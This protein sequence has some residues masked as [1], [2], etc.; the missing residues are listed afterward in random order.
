MKSQRRTLIT[1]FTL[2]I[3]VLLSTQLVFADREP[4]GP[5]D[6]NT[7]TGGF[8]VDD[9]T[10]VLTPTDLGDSL[11]GPGITISTVTYT[12][13]D[14]A[15]GGFSGGAGIIGFDTG[16]VLG[17]GQVGDVIGPNSS[18]N[19]ST[20]NGT[21]GDADLDALS[22]F[23]TFDAAVLEIDFIPNGAS[24]FFRYVFS[25]E[26][27][28]EFVNTQFN[29]AFAFYV[30]GV[31]CAVVD[32]NPITI[33]T[34]NNG[35]PFGSMPNSNPGLYINNDCNDGGCPHDT[36]MDGYT[37]VL[38]CGAVV[39]PNVENTLKL[40]IADASDDIYDANVFIEGG[41]LTTVPTDVSL[42]AFGTDNGTTSPLIWL[43]TLPALLVGLA[44]ILRRRTTAAASGK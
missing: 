19:I 2:L 34:I 12:G 38:T 10:G 32:G 39:T 27:Y 37:T 13:A 30:N 26:E 31:N 17:S 41:S 14:V 43:A 33:N 22:G 16:V 44:I 28:N 35:N 5:K 6:P 20:S 23:T 8:V 21:P 1:L 24:V 4:G 3:S 7:S 18:D 9:L 29:D 42:S 25:S 11:A 15:A 36:E 40:A